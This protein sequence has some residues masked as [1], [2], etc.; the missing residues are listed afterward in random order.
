VPTGYP[1][2]GRVRG[3]E[4]FSML[5]KGGGWGGKG[6]RRFSPIPS[7]IQREGGGEEFP[8]V[9]FKQPENDGGGEGEKKK[10]RIP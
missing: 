8:A 7:F 1:D 5:K 9:S 2:G 6:R 3:L 4:S 10:G